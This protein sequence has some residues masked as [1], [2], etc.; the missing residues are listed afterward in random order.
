MNRY[1]VVIVCLGVIGGCNSVCEGPAAFDHIRFEDQ[2]R[3][4]STNQYEHLVGCDWGERPQSIELFLLGLE[5]HPVKQL[6]EA[7]FLIRA[8]FAVSLDQARQLA[9]SLSSRAEVALSLNVH[10]RKY[11][12]YSIRESVIVPDGSPT[13]LVHVRSPLGPAAILHVDNESS[14]FIISCGFLSKA[15][16]EFSDTVCLNLDLAFVAQQLGASLNGSPAWVSASSQVT[17]IS[18]FRALCSSLSASQFKP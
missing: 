3:K 7:H 5:R 18:E 17:K 9:D 4:L 1:F 6:F 15:N 10:R 12:C 16:P 11:T 13:E 2:F 14:L 8:P